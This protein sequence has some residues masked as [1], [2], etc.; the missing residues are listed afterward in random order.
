[1]DGYEK[2]VYFK[3]DLGIFQK[4]TKT[5]LP[6]CFSD[7]TPG[8]ERV[9]ASHFSHVGTKLGYCLSPCDFLFQTLSHGDYQH[10]S[11]S[12]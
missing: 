6:K 7:A 12:I 5:V 1:M 3:E 8:R 2:S 4:L 9:S 10:L 11:P